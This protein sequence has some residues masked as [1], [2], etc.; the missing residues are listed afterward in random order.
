MDTHVEELIPFYVLGGLN[1]GEME[2][3]ERHLPHCASCRTLLEEM[4]A[5]AEAVPY[6][7]APVRPASRVKQQL[8]ARVE[9]DLRVPH[10]AP[11]PRLTTPRTSFFDFLRAASPALALAS[12]VLFLTAVAWALSLNW[13]VDKLRAL[14]RS[15]AAQVNQQAAAINVLGRPNVAVK[16]FEPTQVQ[17]QARGRFYADFRD[18]QA[19]VVVSGMKPLPDNRVYEVWLIKDKT[20]VGVGTFTV[21][22]NGTGQILI[23]APQVIGSYQISALTEEPQ[24][25]SMLPTTDILMASN[26]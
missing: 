20:P 23:N 16:N 6:A 17:P 13:E 21:D 26:F 11:Q 8:F 1:A 4:R 2:R 9:E 10:S 12:I 22:A 19:L 7:A 3:V 25:G 5:G 18:N 14:N 24:G 15:L